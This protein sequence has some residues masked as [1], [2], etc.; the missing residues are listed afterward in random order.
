MNF[1]EQQDR[2]RSKSAQLILLFGLGVTG[3]VVAVYLAV[4][5]IFF[6][7]DAESQTSGAHFSWFQPE[8]FFWVALATLAVITVSSIIK[9]ISLRRGGSYGAEKLG[10][11][12][13]NPA[14]PAPQE[15]MRGNEG[16]ENA[17][18]AGVALS[19]A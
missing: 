6:Y 15:R 16:E 8:I 7:A 9:I 11:R 14:T 1:F 13:R 12:G 18:P 17:L 10:G 2:S 5:A 4:M 3:I 19:T